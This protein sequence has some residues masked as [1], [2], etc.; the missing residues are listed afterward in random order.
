MILILHTFKQVIIADPDRKSSIDF[1]KA[2]IS[3]N[4][5]TYLIV[6]GETQGISNESFKLVESFNGLRLNIPCQTNSL[7]TTIAAGILL[8]EIRQQISTVG[9]K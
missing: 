4:K 7:N 5:E 8:Y 6:G 9:S 3:P 2:Q 1:K